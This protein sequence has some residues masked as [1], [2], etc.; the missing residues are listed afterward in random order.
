MKN[1]LCFVLIATFISCSNRKE[2]VL[3]KID[4]F[5]LEEKIWNDLTKRILNDNT[6][7]HKLG[8][9]VKLDELEKSLADE[10]TEKKVAYITV[11]K[12]QDCRKVEYQKA[13]D[14]KIGT[15]YLE[16]SSCDSVKT[17]KGYY[18]NLEPI[19]V[20]GIGNGWLTWIDTDPI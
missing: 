16:W 6:V 18:E 14:K 9:L 1:V 11:D 19:E 17:Q 12:S 20:F 4:D 15:Q 13:W 8:L 5:R 3:E 2:I 10:L 7:N